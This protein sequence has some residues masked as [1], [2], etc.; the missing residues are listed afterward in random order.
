MNSSL[1]F[2]LLFCLKQ[3]S[4][5]QV[6]NSLLMAKV[7]EAIKQKF[8]VA[9]YFLYESLNIQTHLSLRHYLDFTAI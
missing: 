9:N 4:L 2:G 7:Y 6:I 3:I 1:L 8:A 5:N